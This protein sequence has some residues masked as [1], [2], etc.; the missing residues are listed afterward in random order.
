MAERWWAVGTGECSS[1]IATRSTGIANAKSTFLDKRRQIVWFHI[2]D[3][4]QTDQTLDP[5]QVLI[6]KN[7]GYIEGIELGDVRIG[8][9]YERFKE[10][11]RSS[12]E[13]TSELQS[14][15]RISYA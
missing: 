7:A 15:L 13:H 1:T 5:F 6:R 11:L 4:V 10:C 9:I 12:E 8:Q 2:L 3:H 14:L